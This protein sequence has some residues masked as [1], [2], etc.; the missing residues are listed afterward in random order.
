MKKYSKQNAIYQGDC[1]DI[2]SKLA[3]KSV[4]LVVTDPPYFLDGLG[5]TWEKGERTS[6]RATGSI[7]G[8]P[9]GMRFDPQHGLKLQEFIKNVA[10]LLLPVMLPGAFALFFS[11]PRL[12]HRMAI[13]LEEA[14][15]EIRDMLAWHF[16]ARAQAKAFSM[17][18]IIEKMPLPTSEKQE[19]KQLLQGRKTPQLRPQ[20]ESILLA[21]KPREGRYIDNWNSY[22]VGLIDTNVRLDG[23]FPSSTI[24]VDTFIT[25]EKAVKEKYNEHLTVKP[26]R[27]LEYLIKLF[28]DKEQVVL[29]PFLG[30]GSTA[31]AALTT[32]RKYVA[33]E[34]N[35]SYIKIAKKRLAAFQEQGLSSSHEEKT[36]RF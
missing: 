30:S 27:L 36:Q 28:S 10:S 7:G 6:K 3:H 25:E 16:T 13:G 2:L 17:D 22:G 33:I 12:A 19:M 29:D 31:L 21:Q 20:F 35:K 9:V 26:L 14:G 32:G 18:H 15:F 24:F 8:L 1:Q 5:D 34:I 23:K 4:H 11:Q